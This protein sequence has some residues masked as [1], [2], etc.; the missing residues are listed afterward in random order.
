MHDTIISRAQARIAQGEKRKADEVTYQRLQS[1]AT[2]N[3]EETKRLKTLHRST[4]TRFQQD[5]HEANEQLRALLSS[6]PPSSTPGAA[7]ASSHPDDLQTTQMFEAVKV[8]RMSG[9][10]AAAKTVACV[11][12]D[13]IMG[14]TIALNQRKDA[15]VR[16]VKTAYHNELARIDSMT[17][18]E[19][20]ETG[21]EP[22]API[23][24]AAASSGQSS[25]SYYQTTGSAAASRTRSTSSQMCAGAGCGSN[26]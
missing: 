10:V 26:A 1:N 23:P 13:L 17:D 21:E 8:I 5:L 4:S 14:T 6:L 9:V 18:W 15:R 2:R 25:L 7:V 22:S 20:L 19:P 3:Q 16:A 24:A 12:Y 11:A